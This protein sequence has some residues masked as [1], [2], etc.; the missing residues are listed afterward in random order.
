[1]RDE[2][3]QALLG[4]AADAVEHY[5]GRKNNLRTTVLPR[6]PR[7]ME[8]AEI[9]ALRE[10]VQAS[11]SV[12]ALALNVGLSTVQAWEAGTRSPDGGNLKLLRVAEAHPEVVFGKMYDPAADPV[13]ELASARKRRVG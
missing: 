11:Q 5:H 12:F 3:F 9:R 4:A 10:R 13:R 2:D 8:A 6:P 1:M 7:A